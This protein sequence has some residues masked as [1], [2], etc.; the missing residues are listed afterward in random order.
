MACPCRPVARPCVCAARLGSIA[1]SPGNAGVSTLGRL[2]SAGGRCSARASVPTP[3]CWQ[4]RSWVRMLVVRPTW[5]RPLGSR[6]GRYFLG[7][8][9]SPCRAWSTDV[10]SARGRARHRLAT[11]RRTDRRRSRAAL[12]ETI[13][14]HRQRRSSRSCDA[15]LCKQ[16]WQVRHWREKP[17]RAAAA[18]PAT[19]AAV[20]ES[21]DDDLMTVATVDEPAAR[22]SPADQYRPWRAHGG[23]C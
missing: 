20:S 16:S 10:Q 2:K 19:I 18:A 9:G 8:A 22:R 6:H 7:S 4:G 3:V 12:P 5:L 15:A 14:R 13:V 17:L 21:Y 1:K 11:I 23:P